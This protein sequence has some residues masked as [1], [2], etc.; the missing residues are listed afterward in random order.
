MKDRKPGLVLVLFLASAQL[1]SQSAGYMGKHFNLSYGFY[2]SPAVIGANAKGNT[3]LG[4][5]NS[6]SQSGKFAFNTQHQLGIEYVVGNRKSIG[7]AA[8]YYKTT[9]DNN[10]NAS[11]ASN[12]RGYYGITGL[13]YSLYLKLYRKHALAPYGNY[14][15]LGPSLNT[16]TSTY[17]PDFMK[18][19]SPDTHKNAYFGLTTQ[20]YTRLDLLVGWGK[21]RIIG[22]RILIDYGIT[23][24]AIAMMSGSWV[25]PES[26]L[27]PFDFRT[28]PGF[29]VRNYIHT[30]T[31]LRSREV[32]R[33]NVF[34][35]VGLLLF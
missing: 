2:C 19:E 27:D 20:K 33:F 25:G 30:T 5:F 29:E 34:F 7:F 6:K 23:L 31:N 3:M 26:I 14:F 11:G 13:N 1:F 10:L 9:Y 35:K 24:Q 8:T 28:R 16:S 12:L 17:D 22:D 21:N 18:G 4:R 15:M 32:N